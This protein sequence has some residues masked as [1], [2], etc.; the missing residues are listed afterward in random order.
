MENKLPNRIFGKSTEG[1]YEKF[2]ARAEKVNET[3]SSR[4]TLAP[5][6]I[7]GDKY[8][9][10]SGT[11][12]LIA[13][14]EIYKGKKWDETHYALADNGLYMPTPELFMKH[15]LNVMNTIQRNTELYDGNNIQGKF[16]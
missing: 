3:N 5:A 7:Q 9:Q 11:S 4:K 15:F 8:I 16:C 14:K 12:A 10:I 13:K 6:D 2:L 1:A